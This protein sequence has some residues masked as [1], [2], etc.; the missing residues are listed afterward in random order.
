MFPK[1]LNNFQVN[2]ET[3]EV[4][5]ASQ[6][7]II[8]V[9]IER[10]IMKQGPSAARELF[11]TKTKLEPYVVNREEF[12]KDQRFLMQAV[13]DKGKQLWKS[14]VIERQLFLQNISQMQKQTESLD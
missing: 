4:T 13:G 11:P 14:L 1:L 6:E 7:S 8:D 5:S 12:L 9:A 2:P 3:L 10:R